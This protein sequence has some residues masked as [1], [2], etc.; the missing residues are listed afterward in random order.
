MD[1]AL[2]SMSGIEIDDFLGRI[3]GRREERIA[4]EMPGEFYRFHKS[5][6][7]CWPKND[8][9]SPT[10]VKRAF[11]LSIPNVVDRGK[12]V[13]ARKEPEWPEVFAC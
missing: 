4:K 9:L 13:F 8:F 7:G 3:F 10:G 1:K 11:I 12:A 2:V 6:F 5:F